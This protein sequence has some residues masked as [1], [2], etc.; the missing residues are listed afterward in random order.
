M[1]IAII[2]AIGILSYLIVV[3]PGYFFIVPRDADPEDNQTVA[4]LPIDEV[5]PLPKEA[6]V[7]NPGAP[8]IPTK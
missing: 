3:L 6:A 2:A 7:V 4:E 5:L 1:R 8:P